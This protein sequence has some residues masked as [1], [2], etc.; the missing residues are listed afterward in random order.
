MK[1]SWKIGEFAGIGVY[2][3]A[4]FLL[5]FGWVALVHW[6]RGHSLEMMLAGIVFILALFACVLLHEFGHALTAKRYGIKTRDITL[7]P[8]GGAS[9]SPPCCS[10]GCGSPAGS[11]R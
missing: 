4:T 11:S 8:I 1:W 9:R 7:L 10:S 3:H 6:T 5:I 2:I